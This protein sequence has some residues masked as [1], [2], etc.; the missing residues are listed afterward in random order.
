MKGSNWSH[1]LQ[2]G[3]EETYP[4]GVIEPRGP[5]TADL[6]LPRGGGGSRGRRQEQAGPPVSGPSDA[7]PPLGR[8]ELRPRG[9][10]GV[11]RG[12]ARG[13]AAGRALAAQ[14][15]AAAGRG[16]G[17]ARVRVGEL[18]EELVRGRLRHVLHLHRALRRRRRHGCGEN[19]CGAVGVGEGEG[20]NRAEWREG[21]WRSCGDLN[22]LGF[23]GKVRWNIAVAEGARVRVGWISRAAGRWRAR[24]SE[25]VVVHSCLPA[26]ALLLG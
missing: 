8:R 18:A 5:A 16:H 25:V 23:E 20:S 10:V 26:S 7:P 22:A 15:E 3:E 21:S 24:V 1:P 19:E 6:G 2:R 11:P 17:A 4:G 13:D 9:G 14:R 12:E